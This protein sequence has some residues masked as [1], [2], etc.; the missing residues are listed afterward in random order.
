VSVTHDAPLEA[1]Q[2]QSRF[3]EIVR[4]PEPPPEGAV[5]M[6]FVT[7]T[8]HLAVE[9]PTTDIDDVPHAAPTPLA[10]SN[11]LRTTS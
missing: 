7:V 8:S 3:V 2:M 1:V 4:A 11:R 5:S 6:E 9:G 10:N